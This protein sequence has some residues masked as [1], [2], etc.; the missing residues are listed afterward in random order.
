MVDPTKYH[1][2]D[3]N[4]VTTQMWG[5]QSLLYIALFLTRAG[6]L[7]TSL[8]L[9]NSD[10]TAVDAEVHQQ[11]SDSVVGF[12]SADSP[13][14]FDQWL[15][16]ENYSVNGVNLASANGDVISISRG[17]VVTVESADPH[18]HIAAVLKKSAPESNFR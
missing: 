10:R 13:E 11:V 15:R 3:H 12:I 14:R 7:P 16:V 8:T 2:L 1:N 6:Y 5:S 4:L 17:G 18:T 9:E